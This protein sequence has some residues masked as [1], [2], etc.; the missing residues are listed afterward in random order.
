MISSRA[1]Y[2]GGPE[3]LY[4]LI[5]NLHHV[6]DIYATI[7]E[8]EPYFGKISGHIGISKVIKIPHRK[9]SINA[10]HSII[11]FIR[12]NNIDIVHSHGKGAGTYSRAA[13][14]FTGT[15]CVHSFHGIH[16]DK[17]RSLGSSLYIIY[18]K[19]SSYFTDAFIATG[20][21][22][23]SRIQEL[24]LAPSNKVVLIKNGV[25]IPEKTA[26]FPDSETMNILTITRNDPA[27]NPELLIPILSKLVE[28]N[29]VRTPILTIVGHGFTDGT[30]ENS[31]SAAGLSKNYRLI[32]SLPDLEDVFLNTFCYLS[33]SK[34]EGLPLSV[35]EAQSYGIPCIVSDVPGN[36]DIIQQGVNG[37]VYPLNSPE[38]AAK[39]I[40]ELSRDE[41][42]WKLLSEN[43]RKYISDNFNVRQMADSVFK[44]YTHLKGFEQ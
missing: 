44:L 36:S 8:D 42:Q 25:F 6:C 17:Y 14:F 20:V 16:T 41:N 29:P 28:L 21:G 18:E 34:M 40:F 12:Q 38:E 15:K 33:T 26:S 23:K 7:P 19:L 30:L 11:G 22:E 32:A 9:F 1:D 10:L 37:A 2:G 4:R 3:H 43:S 31:F 39:S 27:K 24:G 35:L 5:Q 13:S